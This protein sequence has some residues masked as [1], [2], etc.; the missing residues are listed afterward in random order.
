[1]SEYIDWYDH[2]EVQKLYD[3]RAA[4]FVEIVGKLVEAREKGDNA[5]IKKCYAAMKK[6]REKNEKYKKLA[7]ETCF[8]WC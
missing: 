4:K 5:A 2:D 3:S 8:Y 6:H 7:E 1:M